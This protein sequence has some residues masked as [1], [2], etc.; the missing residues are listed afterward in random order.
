MATKEIKAVITAD[1]KASKTIE[2]VGM[3]FGKMAGA[4]AAGQAIFA[5]A[6]A[7][8]N[9]LTNEIKDTVDTTVQ[10]TRGTIKLQ[11]EL[12]VTAETA[13]GL[14]AVG[15]RFG[16]TVDDLSK[17]FGLFAKQVTGAAQGN[18]SMIDNFSHFGISVKDAKGNV[19]DFNA[20]FGETADAFKNAPNGFDK[21]AEAMKLFGRSG[22]DMLPILNLGSQGI[23]ELITKAEKYGLVLTQDNV[24]AVKKYIS[25]QRDMEMAITGVKIQIG[26]A[27]LPTLADLANKLAAFVSSDKF[28]QW[29]AQATEWI[30]TELPKAIDNI[31]TNIL[32]KLIDA[33]NLVWPVVQTLMGWFGQF[34]QFAKENTWVIWGLVAAFVALKTAMFLAGALEAF[35]AVMGGV[36]TAT[37]VT[38][39]AV[40]A[41]WALP[42]IGIAAVIAAF[43]VV[44]QKWAETQDTINN[45][46]NAIASMGSSNEI[47]IGRLNALLRGTAAEAERAQKAL[48]AMGVSQRD[49]NAQLGIVGG[50]ASG[51]YTGRGGAN[52]VAGV[53]HRGEY[54][55]PKTAVD[56]T[57]GMPKVQMSGGGG[58]T[59]NVTFSGIFTGN[60]MEFRQLA[61]KVFQAAGDVAGMQN[62]DITAMTTQNWRRV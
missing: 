21:T 53:V 28:K 14:Q 35:T 23:Q 10:W 2:H 34:I 29:L 18:Q 37:A 25:A 4:V 39:S 17:S 44:T 11:R 24:E 1:D 6:S 38:R 5:G 60:E 26:N 43:V 49:V 42:A 31:T 58:S 51:G 47:V 41:P 12:G 54:V 59:V 57:T 62:N 3:S 61:T 45:T 46:K 9:K 40:L 33:F 27:L 13:S 8:I 7:A 55:L 19:K 20:L 50:Y 36:Q 16:L 56:Q 30:K 32:P 22:K 48:L 15:K 52:E